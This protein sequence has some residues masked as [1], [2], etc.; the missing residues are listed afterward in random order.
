MPD[1]P[2]TPPAP[3]RDT[4]RYWL[5]RELDSLR[6]AIGFTQADVAYHAGVDKAT[7]SRFEQ[8]TWSRGL[9]QIVTAYALLGGVEDPRSIWMKAAKNYRQHG[10]IP[11]AADANL[12]PA[13]LA[14]RLALEAS[15]RR[16]PYG[17]ESQ[18]KPNAN[19][20]RRATG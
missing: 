6:E 9:D 15:L 5:L 16:K 14:A 10:T 13:A 7:I 2:A 18:D 8:G 12:K 4:M 3:G 11:S 1:T 17:D 20:R 19:R